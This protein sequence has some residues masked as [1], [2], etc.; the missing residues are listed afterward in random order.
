MYVPFLPVFLGVDGLSE[1]E[2][3][4]SGGLFLKGLVGFFGVWRG[5]FR[6][7]RIIPMGTPIPPVPFNF[8]NETFFANR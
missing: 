6:R 3:I 5:E 2:S 4:V 7:L 1:G 8:V